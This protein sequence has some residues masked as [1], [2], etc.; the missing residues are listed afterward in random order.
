MTEV[1]KHGRNGLHV[2][3][4]AHHQ[5]ETL[6]W[7]INYILTISSTVQYLEGFSYFVFQHYV[8]YMDTYMVKVFHS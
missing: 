4:Q 7:R 8:P 2:K 1:M 5:F 3:L 6:I